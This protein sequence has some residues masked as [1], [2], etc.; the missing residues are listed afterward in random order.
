[1]SLIHPQSCDCT[2]SEL[3]LFSVPLTQTSVEQGRFVEYGPISI[4]DEGDIEF[5]I[6]GSESEYL[7]LTNSFV[8]IKAKVVDADGTN[9]A[10]NAAVAPTNY[11]LHSMFNNVNMTLNHTVVSS[12]GGTYPYRAYIESL[13][14]YGEE[15]KKTQL[16]SALWYKDTAGNMDSLEAANTGFTKRKALAGASGII[17]MMGKPHLDM[18]F[19][20]RYLINGVDINMHLMPSK[21]SFCL[22]TGRA[23]GA[24]AGDPVI[25]A[26]VKIL[27]A[28]LIVRKV[29]LSAA[30][31]LGHEKALEESNVKYPIR[32]IECKSMTI[33]EGSRSKTEENLFTGQ[34]PKRIV[35]GLV[36]NNGYNGT[37]ATNPYHFK[38]LDLEHIGLTVDGQQLPGKPL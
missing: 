26:R 3:D 19:Q 21:N 7:D 12:S 2:K 13:L 10:A 35:F 37:Y 36:S 16:S 22:M 38:H 27:E 31:Q 11:F 15:A 8:Y 20:D 6:K 4:L 28:K 30:V 23:A 5:D 14:S 29:K 24:D 18:F 32:R 17:E 34:I 33:P 9:L 1:M 25:Q